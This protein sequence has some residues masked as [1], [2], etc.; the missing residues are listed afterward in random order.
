MT[1]SRCQRSEITAGIPQTIIRDKAR[2]NAMDVPVA[3]VAVSENRRELAE[4][5]RLVS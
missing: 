5:L 4:L 3:L 2:M 1:S